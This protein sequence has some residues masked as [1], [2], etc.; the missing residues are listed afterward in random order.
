MTM[1]FRLTAAAAALAG[2]AACEPTKPT[3]PAVGFEG[4]IPYG[5]YTLVGFGKEATPTRD[6]TIRFQ[7]GSISGTGPCNTY[8]GVNTQKLP[9]IHISQ[10]TWG[11]VPCSKHKGFESRFFQ[12][13]TQAQSA[14]WAG[15]VLKITGPTYMTLEM[16]QDVEVAP[17]NVYGATAAVTTVTPAY[18]GQ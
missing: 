10:M 5:T 7:P 6:A 9:N 13:V 14:E 2:L 16:T 18:S 15:E 3:G 12:A 1:M 11:D 17:P 4:G 8:T